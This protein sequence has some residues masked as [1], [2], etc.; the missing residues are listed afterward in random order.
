M[1]DIGYAILILALIFATY[2]AVVSIVNTRTKNIALAASASN[3]LIATCILFTLAVEIMLYALVTNDF[4]IELVRTHSSKDLD[5][6]YKFTAL[7][8]DK[9]G[10]LMFWGWLIS[11]FAVIFT[12]QK[13]RAFSGATRHATGILAVILIFFLVLITIGVDVFEESPVTPADGFGMN[14][15]LQNPGMA[16]HP[17]LLFLGYAGFAVVFAF[18][19][20][21]LFLG[22][23]SND[24]VRELRRWTL[25]S[26]CTLGLANLIGAWWAWDV[27]NWGGYWAWDPVENAG[28]IPWLLGTALV[29]SISIQRK[30]GYLKLWATLLIITT[31]VFT[32]FSPFITHGGLE[33]SPLHGFG[34]SPVPPYILSFIIIIVVGSLCLLVWRHQHLK[35]EGKP[36]SLISREGAFL[37][38][39]ITLVLIVAIVFVGTIIPGL[40]EDMGHRE[41]DI[42]RNFFDWSVGPVLLMLVSFMGICPLLGWRKSSAGLLRHNALFPLLASCLAGIIVLIS[43]I[44]VWYALASLICGLPL[45]TI[46]QEWFRG[47]RAR[48]RNRNENYALALLLLI[49]KNRPRYGGFVVH[50][51]II[52]ITIGVIG[53]SLHSDNW[54]VNLMWAGGVVL[55][56]GAIIAFW[57]D[58]KQTQFAV[59]YN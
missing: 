33:E 51:G 19:V 1:A 55:L 24:W 7:Y 17:P 48:H 22:S 26:W 50:I 44:G 15:Q 42:E 10:S 41:V 5:L 14:P 8:S 45:F 9:A 35:D 23:K 34:D 3:G 57:P 43:G 30:R 31:F 20:G 6:I 40:A 32:L 47:T 38:T 36:S 59:R 53:S 56:L 28:L 37:F 49:W 13:R 11:V 58:R 27:G 54:A 29:H 25:F 4:S 2:A 21:A 16:L 52:L 18:A 39:N 12:F 46:T